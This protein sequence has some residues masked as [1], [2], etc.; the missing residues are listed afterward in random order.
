MVNSIDPNISLLYSRLAP[1]GSLA[2]QELEDRTPEVETIKADPRQSA[3]TSGDG[4]VSL[5]EFAA[6]VTASTAPLTITGS[7]G[8]LFTVNPDGTYVT[9]APDLQ[10][11]P[12]ETEATD[13]STEIAPN[14]SESDRAVAADL[15]LAQ[16]LTFVRNARKKIQ[17][18]VDRAIQ[19][20][21]TPT[22][23]RLHADIERLNKLEARL[24]ALQG[25]SVHHRAAMYQ[26][27]QSPK[28]LEL[29]RGIA[30]LAAQIEALPANPSEVDL[31]AAEATL[32]KIEVTMGVVE[33]Q[34]ALLEQYLDGESILSG[35]FGHNFAD[36]FVNWQ[37]AIEDGIITEDEL[38][39]Q[40]KTWFEQL[41][42]IT[43]DGI[44]MEELQTL[45]SGD[46]FTVARREFCE[47]I[48][49]DEDNENAQE[50]FAELCQAAARGELDVDRY[51]EIAEKYDLPQMNRHSFSALFCGV[52][53]SLITDEKVEGTLALARAFHRQHVTISS[54]SGGN[55]EN[56]KAL[57]RIYAGSDDFYF[58]DT[59]TWV[60]YLQ[61]AMTAVY[62]EELFPAGMSDEEFLAQLEQVA[63]GD[64]KEIIEMLSGKYNGEV[65]SWTQRQNDDWNQLT[66]QAK[67]NLIASHV[68]GK[69]FEGLKPP[70][71]QARTREEME[72][73]QRDQANLFEDLV[74]TCQGD[75]VDP[76]VHNALVLQLMDYVTGDLI[77][78]DA[79]AVLDGEVDRSDDELQADDD[80]PDADVLAET[81]E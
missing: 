76:E 79:Q 58:V 30:D 41:G 68:L 21:D 78:F 10:I 63:E 35:I 28:F 11:S 61:E 14:L 37:E 48:G 12:E 40:G 75:E 16:L 62:G 44:T 57:Y 49:V 72:R 32:A 18:A 67:L 52:Y 77:A 71:E 9:Q 39:A 33:T 13:G 6:Y 70:D 54:Q 46:A 25:L 47:L 27:F 34:V 20:G 45:R 24:Q 73:Q 4:L 74:T 31:V 53:D 42:S 22:A 19:N 1:Q 23:D 8:E 3:D 55:P 43:A 2:A 38:T 81:E 51:N 64:L 26:F 15:A 69:L 66:A 5:E 80:G 65:T 50:A 56:V 29:E 7:N 17:A 59:E 36:G 60:G